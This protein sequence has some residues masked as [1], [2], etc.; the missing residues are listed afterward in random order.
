MSKGIP[1][2]TKKIT[3]SAM[4]AALGVAML[5]I[6]SL[7]ETLDL[8]MAAL[9][10]FFCVFSVIE[11]GGAYPWLIYAVTSVLSILIMPHSM[12]G[13]FYLLFFGFYPILKE[14]LERLPRLLSWLFKIV[15]LNVAL[16][17]C[18]I[19]A[20]F[21]FFGQTAGGN[22]TD[23]FF[24]VFGDSEGGKSMAAVI[25]ALVNITFIIYDIALTRVISLYV[26]KLR[27][28]FKGFKF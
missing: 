22:I 24:L 23:A 11:I 2:K 12:S 18:V 10:S 1:T 3:V 26:I 9:A 27:K 17:I 7:I 13:W 6:G 4:L 8:S 5:F 15:I 21:L 19:A 14:K 20:Y 16:L 25:Y 28:K